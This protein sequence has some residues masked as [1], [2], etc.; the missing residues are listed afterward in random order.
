MPAPRYIDEEEMRQFLLEAYRQDPESNFLWRMGQR[1][2]DPV[3]PRNEK[4]RWRMHP[5]VLM[6]AALAAVAL[7]T[8]IYMSVVGS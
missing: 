4:G 1:F 6:L 2:C 5:L 7:A 8:F 3:Q